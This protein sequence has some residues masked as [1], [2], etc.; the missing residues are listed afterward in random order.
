MKENISK[1]LH[2]SVKDNDQNSVRTFFLRIPKL[3]IK[4]HKKEDRKFWN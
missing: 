3:E 1:L 2:I 4:D